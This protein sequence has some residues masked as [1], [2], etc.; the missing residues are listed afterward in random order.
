MKTRTVPLLKDGVV[1][2]LVT[3]DLPTKDPSA[4]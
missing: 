4:K 3:T 1:Y 2:A